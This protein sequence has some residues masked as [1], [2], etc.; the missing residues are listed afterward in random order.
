VTTVEFKHIPH[1]HVAARKK[2][3]P[4]KV[5]DQLPKGNAYA[6][7]NA[8]LA[9]KITNGVGTMTCAYIFTV[10]SL[11][12]LPAALQSGNTIVIISWVAQT[13]LQ[14]VLLSIIIVGQNIQ[15]TAAD[16]RAQDTYDDA[17]ATLH[18]AAEIQRH[19]GMQDAALGTLT[20][21]MAML[22]DHMSSLV[23]TTAKGAATS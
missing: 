19:L 8:W 18:E 13:F 3:G 20:D 10:I 15:S 7:V 9:V 23:A 16:K 2:H 6:R 4:V 14:L 1:P 21:K 22:T 12:S 5:A 17:D 11:I